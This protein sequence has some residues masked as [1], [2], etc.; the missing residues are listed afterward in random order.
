MYS[1]CSTYSSDALQF[2][3]ELRP[4]PSV[5][6]Q[7][8]PGESVGKHLGVGSVYEQ[9]PLDD[10]D[11]RLARKSR[12]RPYE[13]TSTNSTTPEHAR[14]V[15]NMQETMAQPESGSDS[16]EEE[17]SD[18]SGSRTRT[19]SRS[20]RNIRSGKKR[21]SLLTG[22]TFDVPRLEEHENGYY[23]L[24]CGHEPWANGDA[25]GRGTRRHFFRGGA[26]WDPAL[27]QVVLERE[28]A[29]APNG[30]LNVSKAMAAGRPEEEPYE[31]PEDEMDV[32]IKDD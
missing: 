7:D 1:Q 11:E 26:R 16:E 6:L 2:L 21:M 9:A 17:E 5:G 29:G 32:D 19:R 4:A 15:Y 30:T 10:L 22:E 8:V 25:V 28:R 31:P 27:Q 23:D 13:T 14:F 3:S 24:G 18:A 20:R 12:H